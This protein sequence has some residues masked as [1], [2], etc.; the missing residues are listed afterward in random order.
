MAVGFI[1][2]SG[3]DT[4]VPPATYWNGGG[5]AAEIDN[6]EFYETVGAARVV[7]GGLQVTYASEHIEAYPATRTVVHTPALGQAGI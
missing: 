2:G 6:A 3:E 4:T 7:A 5:F 1:I